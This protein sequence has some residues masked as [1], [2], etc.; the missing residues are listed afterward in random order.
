M[1]L[2][3][4]GRFVAR[5]RCLSFAGRS[6]RGCRQAQT[7]LG[8]NPCFTQPN[9]CMKL[10]MF[11]IFVYDH[12]CSSF[13]S[14]Q[15]LIGPRTSPNVSMCQLRLNAQD[16]CPQSHIG[17]QSSVS[18]QMLCIKIIS[19]KWPRIIKKD[20]W[21]TKSHTTSAYVLQST[22]SFQTPLKLSVASMSSNGL[23]SIS[24]KSALRPALISP[25][26]AKLKR[27]ALR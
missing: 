1:R 9:T 16:P 25:R 17:V 26:S 2:S 23:P 4:L 12:H 14:L 6:S 19:S 7:N 18:V 21:L 20:D 3:V 13:L 8:L 5:D 27:F 15:R 10:K 22:P 24:T 11:T